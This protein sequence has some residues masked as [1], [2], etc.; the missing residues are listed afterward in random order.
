MTLLTYKHF[1]F[2]MEKK[3]CVTLTFSF[4]L[5]LESKKEIFYYG[6]NIN[7]CFMFNHNVINKHFVIK[8]TTITNKDGK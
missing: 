7:Y 2:I 6:E 5:Y 1:L 3:N 4:A 8:I